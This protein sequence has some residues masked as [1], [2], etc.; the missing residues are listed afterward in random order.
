MMGW[1]AM[2]WKTGDVN[3]STVVRL[4]GGLRLSLGTTTYFYKSKARLKYLRASPGKNVLRGAPML[5]FHAWAFQ[6]GIIV[7]AD[8]YGNERA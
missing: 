3:G 5:V 1:L 4:A 8:V 6:T 7:C 2:N